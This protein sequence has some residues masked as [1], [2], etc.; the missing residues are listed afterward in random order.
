MAQQAEMTV[1]KHSFQLQFTGYNSRVPKRSC[2]QIM[3]GF[4]FPWGLATIL[5][6]MILPLLC[7]IFVFLHDWPLAISIYFIDR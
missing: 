6:L 2:C 5:I 1:D 3:C 7:S 4:D